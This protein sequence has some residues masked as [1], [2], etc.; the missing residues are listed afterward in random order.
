MATEE[1]W[2]QVRARLT[3]LAT[4]MLAKQGDFYEGV[5]SLEGLVYSSATLRA[6][7]GGLKSV[8]LAPTS[9]PVTAQQKGVQAF[10]D[11]LAQTPRFTKAATYSF[12]WHYTNGQWQ[13]LFTAA[14]VAQFL[15]L[16]EFQHLQTTAVQCG[17]TVTYSV[18]Y[19][20]MLE[21]LVRVEAT[22]EKVAAMAKHMA[23]KRGRTRLLP[24]HLPPFR[25]RA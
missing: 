13:Q 10:V 19:G 18:T 6:A 11:M 15:A 22:A 4:D 1:V 20:Q 16:P 21:G 2:A 5:P 8:E 17:Y 12:D 25:R 23:V 14:E 7:D 3:Q 24:V 9:S